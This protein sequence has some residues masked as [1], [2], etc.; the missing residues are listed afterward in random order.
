M[1]FELASDFF[2]PPHRPDNE[3]NKV[4]TLHH[5]ET[6]TSKG[7]SSHGERENIDI[8]EACL[9]AKQGKLRHQWTNTK[10]EAISLFTSD[11]ISEQ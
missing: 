4:N 7:L 2:F 5:Y 9:Q 1:N 8:P 10:V 3:C 6:D 11:L